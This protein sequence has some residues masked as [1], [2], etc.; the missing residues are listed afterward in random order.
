MNAFTLPA[1]VVVVLRTARV[2]IQA[3]DGARLVIDR[4][5]TF[6][7]RPTN[8]FARDEQGRLRRQFR[9]EGPPPAPNFDI[10]WITQPPIAM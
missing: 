10:L 8:R 3:P 1:G 9:L 2:C 5:C 6:R 7:A 4:P